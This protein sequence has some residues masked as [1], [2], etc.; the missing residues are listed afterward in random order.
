LLKQKREN[1]TISSLYLWQNALQDI[2]ANAPW[3]KLKKNLLMFLQILAVIILALVFSEPFLKIYKHRDGD[4]MIIIDCSLSMQSTDIRPNR[5][6]AA[7]NDAIKLVESYGANTNF[8]VIASKGTPKLLLHQVNDKNKV[9]QEIK[10]LQATDTAENLEATIDLINTLLSDNSSMQVSWFSDNTESLG[11]KY[12]N[13]QKNSFNKNVN[14]KD[15]EL[16]NINYYSYNRNGAN[17]AVTLLSYR[18]MQNINE[19]TVLSRIGNF[20]QQDAEIDVSLYIDGV[21]FDAKRLRI[22]AGDSEN[23]Y[24]SGIPATASV[25]ECKIDTED[26][27]EKDNKA[28]VLVLEN[29]TKKVLLVTKKNIY[30][31]KVLRLI[32]DLELYRTTLN[33]GFKATGYDLYIF[34]G[35]MPE[36]LP[37]DGHIIIF[38]PPKNQL[39]P[40]VGK[41]EYTDIIAAEHKLFE[42]LKGD[43]TFSALKTNLYIVP[44]WANPMMKNNEGI[45]AF[46]GYLDKNR[47]IVFGFDLHETNLPIQPFF[48]VIMA[49]TVQELIPGGNGIKETSSIY[50]GDTI[51]L[52]IDPKAEE[53]YVITPDGNKTLIAPPFPATLYSE[54]SQIGTYIL[55]QHLRD[56]IIEQK[57]IV[58]APSEKEYALSWLNYG[59][60]VQRNSEVVEAQKSIFGWSLKILLL[61]ILLG[62]LILEWWVFTNGI[63]I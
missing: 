50:A 21:F 1:Y 7:K 36:Q 33:D 41:S 49:K 53:V 46:E 61:W 22:N 43:F 13:I 40:N 29:R 30:L 60:P 20:S 11:N 12:L 4:V 2:E 34:D 44:Q 3:Q 23:L 54:T 19:I 26:V 39:F 56:K 45:V 35:D 38:N 58:N 28:S 37:E 57:F 27:L 47:I 10:N 32:P 9:I 25:L 62:I 48:P 6:E 15:T 59:S 5:F 31:E 55:E 8:S 18:K 14:E 16:K 42:D 17:Y 51:E 52:S 24:W 63:T